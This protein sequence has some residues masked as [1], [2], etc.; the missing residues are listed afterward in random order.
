MVS[1]CMNKSKTV[2]IT[3]ATSGVG[4]ALAKRLL[5]EGHRVWALG[6]NKE[7]LQELK[8]DGAWVFPVDLAQPD[9]LDTFFEL[10]DTPDIVVF[11]AGVGHFS[12]TYE[13]T[14]AEIANALTVNVAAPMQFTRRI[15]PRM[16]EENDGQFIFLG[17]Q[18]GKVATSKSSVYAASKHALIGYTNALRLELSAFNIDVTTIHPSP[19]DTP[20]LD[21]ADT[22]GQYRSAVG[23]HLLSVET[24]VDAI[25]RAMDKPVREINLPWYMGLTSKL[26]ALAPGMTERIGRKFFLKK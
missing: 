8:M 22:T 6:R 10:I 7:V 20:F 18:A 25:I 26:Y 15:L 21:L 5:A 17:S 23:R 1:Y 4:Y 3:G 9:E 12:Y 16:M 2:L 19:I 24:V 14:D 13:A 11:S